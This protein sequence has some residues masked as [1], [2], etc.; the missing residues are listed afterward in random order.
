MFLSFILFLFFNVLVGSCGTVYHALWF[1]SV[2]SLH[3]FGSRFLLLNPKTGNIL[4]VIL[5]KGTIMSKF[6]DQLKLRCKN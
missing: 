6:L 5:G 4:L 3:L 2:R 1:G